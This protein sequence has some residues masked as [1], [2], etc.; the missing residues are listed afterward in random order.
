M[1]KITLSDATL[2][3]ANQ[4]DVS[5]SFRE[6]LAI[7][8]K[9]DLVKVDAI[10]LPLLANLKENEVICHTISKSVKNAVVKIPVGDEVEGVKDAYLCVKDA[11]KP[12]LQVVMPVSTAQME[13]FYHL[14]SSAM[15]EKIANLVES[16]KL[17]HEEVEFC[18]LDAFRA[19]EG[20]IQKV[21]QKVEESG[22]TAITISDEA[23]D[24]FPEEYEIIVKKIKSVCN[25]KV[26]VK[27]SDKL[28]LGA[29]CALSAIKA[30]ADG[31]VTSSI[32]EYLSSA[33][34]ADITRSK[35]YDMD[36]EV[37]VDVTKVKTILSS[38]ENSANE[39]EG[40]ST[41]KTNAT[42]GKETSMTEIVSIIKNLGYELSDED[43][44]KVYEEFKRVASKKEEIEIKELEA[45]IA[46][47][48][49]QV[50]STY[51][52]VNY[53]VNSGN[54]I[55]ATANVTLEKNGEKFTGVSTGDG[56]I[57][58]AFHAIEQVIGH[59]YELD[60]FQVHAV[61]KGREAV[62]SSIIRLR[63]E[64]KLYPGNGVSTDIVGACIRAYIN[65]LNKIVFEGE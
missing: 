47:T 42:V 17:L 12:C 36:A 22:A 56:P 62:G 14:K 27:P 24:A 54:I 13:Y 60:D 33:T 46:S 58:A 55:P 64:G 44:G 65:A 23:G 3:I 63:A 16:A 51:H 38:I 30:G 28:K 37:T 6:R 5:L 7:A 49:M 40:I 2:S 1:K 31:I 21:A 43:N 32:G 61:T 4:Q 8:E 48:A 25:L 59:H 26:L 53:V 11:V 20:F 19:E 41:A 50:P 34:L 9:L 57:D 39:D 45:I 29:S 35:K 15:L 52:L 10:E 18:A